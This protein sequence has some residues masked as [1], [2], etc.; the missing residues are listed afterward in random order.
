M[1]AFLK[2]FYEFIKTLL[3]NIAGFFVNLWTGFWNIF[4]IKTYFSIFELYSPDFDVLSWILAVISI[5]FVVSLFVSIFWLLFIT[6]R[7]YLR[8]RKKVVSQDELL[9]QVAEL[10]SQVENLIDEKSKIMALKVSQLGLRPGQEGELES[11]SADGEE[12]AAVGRFVKLADV[13]AR[14]AETP[15]NAPE[16]EEIT[17]SRLC[18]RF[19][20]FACSKLKLYYPI[21]IIRYFIS[22]MAT[23]KIIILEGISGTGKTSLPYA[24]GKFLSNDT[25]IIPVQPSWR[26]KSELIGYFNEFTK[27]FNETDFLKALYEASYREDVGLIVLDEMNLARIEYYFA[28]ILSLLEMP[29][30][31]EWT[32]DIVPDTWETDPAHL[33]G[34][35][36]LFPTNIWFVGTANNDDSTFTITDKVYDRSTPISINTKGIPFDAPPDEPMNLNAEYLENLFAEAK[37]AHPLSEEV[38]EK[39][40]QLDNFVITNFRLAFGNRILKQIKDFV[41]VYVGCGGSEL[42][43]VDFMLTYK[44]FRKFEVLNISFAQDNLKK[45]IQTLDKIFGKTAMPLAKDYITNLINRQ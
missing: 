37:A 25:A 33:K 13:D 20:N 18:E 36:L 38:L 11:F 45:L 16:Q 43:G 26:D 3:E 9:E 19:R 44:I 42:D 7:R 30:R 40:D 17:L 29:N 10:N 32:V 39:I 5:L 31:S 8:F 28:E 34:G 23:S 24:M 6:I 27:R 2:F 15:Y 21:S 22:G 12:K 35:K 41:P 14:Y 1:D 4:A